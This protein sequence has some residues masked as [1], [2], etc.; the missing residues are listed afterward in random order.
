MKNFIKYIL[1]LTLIA[2]IGCKVPNITA[3]DKRNVPASFEENN[4]DTVSSA[5][6]NR[7]SFFTSA[8]LN[9]LIDTVLA[10]NY[11]LRTATERIEMAQAM[12]N[13]AQGFLRPQVNAVAAPAIR[14]Y[15]L[16]T[17]D[18]AGNISTDIEKGK[19]VPIDL[20]DY[21]FGLQ[22]SW[23]IDLWGKL[24]NRKKAS[25]ARFYSSIEGRNLIQTALVSETAN[26]YYELLALDE[27]IRVLEQTISLQEEAIELVKVQ[28]E[29]AMVNELAVQQFEAQLLGMKSLRVQVNQQIREIEGRINVLAGRYAQPIVRDTSFYAISEPQVIKAGIPAQMIVRRPD[30]RR[31]EWELVATKADLEA[32][33][34]AFFPSITLNA[35]VGLQAYKAGLLFRFPESIAYSLIAG[36]SAP[37]INR[38]MIKGEFAR[39]NARQREALYEYEGTV[40]NAFNEV[41]QGLKRIESLEQIYEMKTKEA[42]ISKASIDVSSELFRTGRATYLEVLLARQAALRSNIEMIETRKNQYLATIGVYRALGGY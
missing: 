32:A 11:D 17:M 27:E 5:S 28:K 38:A 40:V 6:I 10:N 26:A 13:Q 36:I 2:G 33:R 29:A 35:G 15:G 41:F 14:R 20:P 19:R 16:Y 3:I 18:G 9:E 4:S 25:I 24:K 31:A 21:Y 39:S 34:A 42:G 30:I 37:I 23:E 12:V 7:K 1:L 22:S 8:Y